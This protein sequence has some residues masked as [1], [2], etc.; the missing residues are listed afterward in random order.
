MNKLYNSKLEDFLGLAETYE[1]KNTVRVDGICID[2]YIVDL[3]VNLNK[4]NLKTTSSCSGLNEDHNDSFDDRSDGYISIVYLE[5][6]EPHLLNWFMATA[7]QEGFHLLAHH[8]LWLDRPHFRIG[9]VTEETYNG[10]DPYEND[11]M[12]KAQWDSLKVR[13]DELIEELKAH[14]NRQNEKIKR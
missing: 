11:K 4:L 9:T 10:D 12:K 6:T 8:H 7:E 3:V 13:L 2:R 1:G 14:G 5:D